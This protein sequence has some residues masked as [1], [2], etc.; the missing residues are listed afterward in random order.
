MTQVHRPAP[1]PNWRNGASLDAMMFGKKYYHQELVALFRW[2]DEWLIPG[3]RGVRFV[4]EQD[5]VKSKMVEEQ[6]NVHR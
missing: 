3:V 2:I 5:R 1:K 4:L 6:F